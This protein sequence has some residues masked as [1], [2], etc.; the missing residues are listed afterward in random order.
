VTRSYQAAVS[1]SSEYFALYL[2]SDSS[3]WLC[4]T[5]YLARSEAQPY[6]SP[7]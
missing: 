7:H 5:Q 1:V 6:A 4:P 2:H 3:L